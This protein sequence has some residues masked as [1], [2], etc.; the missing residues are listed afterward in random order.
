MDK[1]VELLVESKEKPE[2]PKYDGVFVKGDAMFLIFDDLK[3]LRSSPSDSLQLLL[4]HRHKD[5]SKINGMS[6]HV[7]TQKI[8][9]ILKQALTSES[10]LSDVLLENRESKPSYSFSPYT[11][12]SHGKDCVKIKVIVSKSQNKV[13]F[14]EVDGDFVDFLVSFLT[15]PLG[16]ILNLMDGKLSLG[17]IDNLYASVK[18]LDS[19]WFIGS[20]NKSLLNPKVAPQ[21]GCRNNPLNA[22]Q[23]DNT[24][25][26]W[27]GTPVEKYNM[28]NDEK[29]KISKKKEMLRDP[30]QEMKLFD[31]RSSVVGSDVH[32]KYEFMKRPC[33]FVVTDDL[34]VIPITTASS[35]PYPKELGNF[36]LDDVEE[37]MVKIRKKSHE[38]L[39]LLRASLTCKEAALTQSLFYL[40]R[41]WKY[42]RWIP[43]WS[44]LRR[45]KKRHGNQ[46]EVEEKESEG[47]EKKRHGNQKELEDKESE[48][49]VVCGMRNR[50]KR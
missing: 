27:Y 40:L 10:P 23:E 22:L 5:L 45:K 49:A 43:F 19:S 12:P 36:K 44:V 50:K 6:K 34:K 33:L 31:P 30:P 29:K 28:E 38:A 25:K 35:F 46:K 15:T 32:Q 4:K 47:A 26:Y 14:A 42:Q 8:F 9:H 13:L 16:S 37:H 18:D 48:S 20:S 21:F 2:E 1:E 39:N 41:K 7:S 11:S 3:V 24:P 17:S